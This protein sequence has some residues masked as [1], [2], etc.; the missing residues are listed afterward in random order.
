[1]TELQKQFEKE[2]AKEVFFT[3][4]RS[5]N[6]SREYVHWL[7]KQLS[8]R[9]T[10]AEYLKAAE[11]GEVSMIDAEHVVSL[12]DEAR[13]EMNALWTKKMEEQLQLIT[14]CIEWF[15]ENSKRTIDV[16][17]LINVYSQITTSL[18]YLETIRANYHEQYE[19]IVF[20]LVSDGRSVASAVNEANVKVPELYL[21][22]R[23]MDA[24]YRNTDA[25][26]TIIS[27]AKKEIANS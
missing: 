11:L 13:N 18:F 16:N 23:V 12:L 10:K 20:D 26:R 9:Y 19:K 21:L 17:K 24:A 5:I 4:S 22:R 1:M 25:M 7:E 15:K 27:F 2:T 8:E 6:Y 3:T 14:K